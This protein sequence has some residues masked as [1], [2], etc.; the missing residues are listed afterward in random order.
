MSLV[1]SAL[2]LYTSRSLKH[3]GLG[4][5]SL[6]LKGFTGQQ[7]RCNLALQALLMVLFPLHF[8]FHFLYYTDVGSITF[9]LSAYLVQSQASKKNCFEY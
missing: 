5:A 4:Q 9:V 7:T 1:K 8:F 3:I 6:D 2:A